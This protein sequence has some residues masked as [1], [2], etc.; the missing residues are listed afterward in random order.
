MN[1][2]SM[3]DI[4]SQFNN[5]LHLC[6][7]FTLLTWIL[8]LITK[9]YSQV[10]RLWS[11]LPMIYTFV[12][13]FN[14]GINS[15]RTVFASAAVLLWGLRLTFNF[16]RR[17]GYNKDY[18][19]Y[20]W[21]HVK[22]TIPNPIVW[23][24]FNFLFIHVF[25]NII[26]LL[27]GT[28][29]TTA[30]QTNTTYTSEDGLAI[31][32]FLLFWTIEL[33]ADQQQ[34]EFQTEKNNKIATRKRLTGDYKLGFLTNGLFKYCRHPNYF[35]E[36]GQWWSIYYLCTNHHNKTWHFTVI[37]PFILTI[38]FH[39]STNLTE[40]LSANKYNGYSKYQESVPRLLPKFLNLKNITEYNVQSTPVRRS[41]RRTP[42]KKKVVATPVRRSSRKKS[43]Y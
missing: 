10:D 23:H 36:M 13:L 32:F 18:E 38:L 25:Q 40:E 4:L 5:N 42:V 19:D 26:L 20:R 8:S 11:I 7:I 3:I 33:I 31:V 22:S 28:L 2:L 1:P 37:G 29:P 16:Y 35:A 34:Y 6:V 9:N 14:N 39:F 41:T 27:L 12:G 15:I 30:V 17:G 43:K 24:I 21:E